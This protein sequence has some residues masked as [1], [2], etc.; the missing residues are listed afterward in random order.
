MHEV[1]SYAAWSIAGVVIGYVTLLLF[2]R[3]KG[4]Y[5]VWNTAIYVTRVWR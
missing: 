5:K 1:L 3:A 2:W 4:T